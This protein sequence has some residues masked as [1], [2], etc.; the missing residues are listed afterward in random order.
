V[1]R[2]SDNWSRGPTGSSSSVDFL[3]ALKLKG[4]ALARNPVALLLWP[5]K[6]TEQH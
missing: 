5:K 6:T 2:S 4:G 1:R 3:P